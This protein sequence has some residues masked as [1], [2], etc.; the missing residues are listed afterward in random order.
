MEKR[1]KKT[2]VN[3]EATAT[4]IFDETIGGRGRDLGEKKADENVS[5]SFNSKVRASI[6]L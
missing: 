5:D 6:K 1:K 3:K 2:I 4:F